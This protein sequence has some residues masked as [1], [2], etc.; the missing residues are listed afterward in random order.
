MDGI[1]E[2]KEAAAVELGRRGG[3]KTAE[4]GPE[5]YA[6]I[7]AKRKVR[8][9]GRPKLPTRATHAGRLSIGDIEFDCAVLEDGTRVIS[10]TRFMAAMGMYR[11]GAVSVRREGA[12][13][14]LFLAHKN[15]RPYADRHLGDAHFELL[16]YR[17]ER[18]KDARGI[19]AELLPKICE[20]WLDANKDG[21]LG[22]RQVKIAEKADILMRGLAHVGIIALVDEATGYQ[23]IRD[24]ETLQKILDQYLRHELAAWAKR[25]PDEFYRHMFRLRNWEWKGMKVNRPQ[26][27]G[28]YTNDLVYERLAPG[29]LEELESR[30]PKGAK[31]RRRSKHHQWLSLDVGHPA[32]QQHLGIIIG[33]MRISSHW[34]EFFSYIERALPKKGDTLL[35]PYPLDDAL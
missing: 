7:Q 18:N 20:I 12:P 14:P 32:L 16:R 3:N 2:N 5:Y 25:F 31:G 13:I 8:K 9:G 21:V 15:L 30:N 35:L 23:A 33:F 10:E 6:E 27:V 19:P 26:V 28:K 24:R 1:N 29:I 34:N 22:K 11:S 4:R 17:T